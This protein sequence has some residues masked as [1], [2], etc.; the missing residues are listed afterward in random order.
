MINLVGNQMAA[1]DAQYLA[2]EGVTHL[3]NTASGDNKHDGV[4]FISSCNI[5]PEFLAYFNNDLVQDV[6]ETIRSTV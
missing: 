5:N 3:L 4:M 1:E 2:G 6:V